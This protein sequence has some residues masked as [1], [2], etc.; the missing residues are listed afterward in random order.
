MTDFPVLQT[1]NGP[2][3]MTKFIPRDRKT[4]LPNVT[5]EAYDAQ[6]EAYESWCDT[7]SQ[8]RWDDY[9]EIRGDYEQHL[10]E[11]AAE[12]AEAKDDDPTGGLAAVM[13]LED[14]SELLGGD[15]TDM[16]QVYAVAL[17]ILRQR[18]EP[19]TPW[20]D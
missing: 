15:E 12:W 1:S 19:E 4:G 20:I 9:L 3:Q 7:R 18:A 14:A 2:V 11:M 10:V 13:A 6:A 8:S 5:S 17:C 16:A